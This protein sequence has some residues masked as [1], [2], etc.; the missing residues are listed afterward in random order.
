MT[1][2]ERAAMIAAMS[3]EERKALLGELKSVTTTE[4]QQ[5][6]EAYEAI[7]DD[8]LRR[9]KKRFYGYLKHGANFKKWLRDE[10][11][12]FYEVL[13]EYG[14][15]KRGDQL[16]YTLADD[17]FRFIV[18][19]SK[20]KGFDERAD[21]AEKRLTEFLREWVKSKSDGQ[22]NPMYKL[23]MMMIQRNEVGDLDYKSISRLYELEED[24][25]D[26]EYSEIMGLFKESNTI[27]KT[28]V[29]FL[30]E[31][32]DKNGKFNR[33]EPSFNRL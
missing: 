32:R 4:K 18:K 23:A 25:N 5:Q 8:L 28:A 6:K 10:A 14:Q 15:L 1:Q 2:E 17:D 9:I 22:K 20:V 16:G 11:E 13:K 29:Y 19:G 7:R 31:E 3:P 27:E 24:F 21:V 26:P 30:F 12:A 33:V